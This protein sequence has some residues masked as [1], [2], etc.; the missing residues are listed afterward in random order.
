MDFISVSLSLERLEAAIALNNR[1]K[2]D[3]SYHII[4]KEFEPRYN[5][6]T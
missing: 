6:D 3:G 4:Y 2:I 1:P 5:A